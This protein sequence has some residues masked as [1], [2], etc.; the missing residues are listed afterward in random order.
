MY[1]GEPGIQPARIPPNQ[2]IRNGKAL[3]RSMLADEYVAG[4]FRQNMLDAGG[5]VG[6]TP[7]AAGETPA[8]PGAKF[9]R[10]HALIW[11]ADFRFTARVACAILRP[12]VIPLLQAVE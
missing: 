6:G 12:Y 7:T 11:G 9:A 2:R 5:A 1:P 4:H 10:P 8:L 3:N